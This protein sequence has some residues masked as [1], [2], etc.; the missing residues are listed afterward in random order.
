M[1]VQ[2]GE[3]SVFAGTGEQGYSGDNGPATDAKLALPEG[4]AV[5]SDGN[6]YIADTANG[7][8]REVTDGIIKTAAGSRSYGY[9]NGLVEGD[10][11]L[12]AIIGPQQVA[13]SPSG[14]LYWID[15]CG[16]IASLVNGTVHIVLSNIQYGPNYLTFDPQGNLY[17]STDNGVQKLTPAGVLSTVAGSPQCG[18]NYDSSPGDFEHPSG[19][20]FDHSGNLFIADEGYNRRIEEV[21]SDR[22]IVTVAGGGPVYLPCASP[23]PPAPPPPYP[24][25]GEEESLVG[26]TDVAV[27]PSN[28]L[29]IS[30]QNPILDELWADSTGQLSGTSILTEQFCGASA[31]G[32]GSGPVIAGEHTGGCNP[33]EICPA[34]ASGDPVDLA[35]GDFWET[36]TD[37]TVPGRGIP[38]ALS[39]SYD[40]FAASSESTS[41][42]LGFGWAFSYG[43]TLKADDST[44][45]VT[46]SQEN[47]SQ[48][49]FAQNRSGGYVA[50]TR[51]LGTLTH[52][53]DGSW[54]FT[55]R[56]REKFVFNPAGQLSAIQDPNG[57]ATVL[58]YDGSGRLATVTD[59][60][61]RALTF[62]YDGQNRISHVTDPA[63]RSVQYNYDNGGNLA[64]VTDVNG[65]TTSYTYDQSNQLLTMTNPLGHATLTNTYDDDGRVTTQ[66]DTLGH[67]THFDYSGGATVVTSPEGRETEYVFGGSLLDAVIQGFGTSSQ[68]DWTYSYDRTTDGVTSITDP[69]GGTTQL[70]YDSAGNVT[71][72]TD[73][74]G[75]SHQYSYDARNDLTGIQDWGNTTLSYDQAGNLLSVSTPLQYTGRSQTWTYTRGDGTH[76]DDVT[77]VTDPDGNTSTFAYNANGDLTSRTDAAGDQTTYQYDQIGRPGSSVSPVGNAPG[78]NPASFTTSYT[79]DPAGDLLTSTDPLNHQTSYAYDPDGKL[80]SVTDP[81]NHTTS[82]TYDTDDRLTT[83]ARAD[84]T[85]LGYGYDNDGN[86]TSQTDGVGHITTY[87]YDALD[88]VASSADPLHRIATYGYD[89]DGNL[90]SLK[91]QQGRITTYGYNATNE[92]TSIR[93]S[94]GQ[95]P[96]ITYG[97]DS[98]RQRT[99]MTDGTGTTTYSYDSLHRL[100]S[101][102]DGAGQTINYGYDLANNETSITYPNQQTVNRTFDQANRLH[103]VT[104]WL[105]NTTTFAYDADSNLASS[106]FPAAT[107]NVDT[108]GYNA[109]DQL[110]SAIFDQ[111]QTGLAALAYTRDPLGELTSETQTG[112]PGPADLSYSYNQLNQLTSAGSSNYSYDNAG[113][114]TQ[115]A[116]ASAYSY[117]DA[118]QLTS[119]PTATYTNDQVGERTAST[120]TAGGQTSYA[121]NQAGRLISYTPPTG[122][123]TSFAY[124]GDGIRTSRSTG[125]STSNFKWDLTA[126]SPTLLTDGQNN[127]IYGPGNT[128]I[129]QI[130]QAGTPTYLHHDQLGSTRLI[131]DQTGNPAGAFTYNPYG[132]LNASSGTATTPFGYADQ[133]TDPQT[134]L[135]YDLN[136]YYDPTTGQFISGDPLQAVTQQPYAYAADTPTNATDPTGLDACGSLPFVSQVCG[137]LYSTGV[138]NFAAGALSGMSG[139]FSTQLAG[140]AFSFNP[141]CA[142]FGTPGTIGSVVGLVGGLLDGT[143]EEAVAAEDG[144]TWAEQ[145]GILRDAAAGTGNFGL[146]PATA[147]EADVL[148][149]AWVGE[150]STVASDSKTLLSEDG[151]RQYRPPSYKPNLGIQQANF[152]SRLPGQLS[153]GWQ[154]N[155]H[156]D[157]TGP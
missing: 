78:A 20:A 77:G 72:V 51:V 93:F 101:T 25:F 65:G 50:D 135:E 95:T 39:R 107:G 76:P 24:I 34:P 149:Q 130:N 14:Q 97:Y 56:A 128:P 83:A 103:G 89:G 80:T 144:L 138:S 69:R 42:P 70:Q 30:D 99:R 117:D 118:S 11:A 58:A 100:T 38:L 21:T 79:Y 151:M 45:D 15:I 6:V 134:G 154:G 127:Y 124:N 152:E 27:D 2:R 139:G 146:G 66:T 63:G 16:R 90:T 140:A 36:A 123:A 82:Y 19:M 22:G 106:T 92:L 153:R 48:I 18:C 3:I 131:T 98:D 102:T 119:S 64:S 104:D 120:P 156:L 129:E 59:P 122:P 53:P 32:G 7:R 108:N 143:S 109:A 28:D 73:P 112:L 88:R 113:N 4:V 74:S 35:T 155:G 8:I 136:R 61:G 87:S 148:G 94:D 133:Y 37:L 114:V 116:G 75:N 46:I 55:R 147:S 54:T 142:N 5:D 110:M 71:N 52:N 137:A 13:V 68:A 85:T 40:A 9:C 44:G 132:T 31:G 121:Y 1:K 17:F 67:A 49:V 157:I 57:Y 62:T 26:P 47:G 84:S 145:S 150:G 86:L 12:A 81:A 60:E 115:L 33:S 111:G 41:G 43:M 126:G 29:L 105:G 91:D 23:G 10:P 125:T 141:Q 96:N